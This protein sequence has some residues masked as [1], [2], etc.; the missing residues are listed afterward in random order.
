M[1]FLKKKEMQLELLKHAE[2]MGAAL[3]EETAQHL[4]PSLCLVP[5]FGQCYS[6]CTVMGAKYTP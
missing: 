2:N 3:C 5:G 6:S 1:I 4:L